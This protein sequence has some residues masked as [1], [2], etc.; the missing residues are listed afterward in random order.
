[1]AK[2]RDTRLPASAPVHAPVPDAEPVSTGRMPIRLDTFLPVAAAIFLGSLAI[3][4]LHLWQIRDA[5]FF[6]FLMGDAQSYHA[7]AQD[8]AAGN[9]VGTD[10][11]YQAPLYPYFLGLVYTLFGEGAMVVRV[12]QAVL[13]SLACVFLTYA[14]W[15]LFSKPVGLIAGA[16]LALYAPALFFDGLIQKSV[17]DTVFLCLTLALLSELV[18][19]PARRRG[20]LAVGVA[21][22]CLM[23]TRENAL[24]F[25]IVML[26]WLLWPLQRLTRE[27]LAPAAFLLA[28]LALVLLPVAAR[29]LAVNGE[30][31][32]TTSQFGPNFYIGNNENA[33]GF[34]QPLRFGR[35]DPRFER[36]DATDLAQEATGRTLSP[37]EVSRYWTGRALTY[38][39]SQPVDW[40]Q[41]MGRKF[42]LAWNASE[43][44]DTEDQ[45]SYAD[46]SFPLSAT[47][48]VWHFGILAP[49]AL[50]GVWVTWSRRRDLTLLYLLAGAYTVTLVAFAIMARYRYPLVPFLILFAAAGVAN[51]GLLLRTRSRRQLAWG[52]AAV[53]ALAIFCNWP[54]YSMARMRAVTDS[55]VGTELQLRGDIDAAI[56]L[57]RESLARN[58]NNAVAISNLGTALAANGQ[59]D[60]AITQHRRALELAPDDAD[61]HFNLGNALAARGD[62]DEAIGHLRS[63]LEV[64]PGFAEAHVN[65]GNVLLDVE[66]FEEAERH[67]RRAT[68]LE[69][70]WVQPF[71]NLGLLIM[72]QDRLAEGTAIFRQALAVDPDDADAHSNLGSALQLAG[73]T[74][75]ALTHFRRVIE[76]APD[77]AEAHN[78]LGMAL[79][80]Q[81][82]LEEA[83]THFERAAELDP[84]FVEAHNNLAM[85]AQLRGR[86]DEAIAR[87]RD[88]LRIARNPVTYN[89]LGIILAQQD[90]QDEAITRFRQAIAMAPDQA[91]AHGNLA[92]LLQGRGELDDAITHFQEAVR[93]A[94]DNTDLADRLLAA[95]AA[96]AE[97]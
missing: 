78:D 63:A 72:A 91:D 87:Y 32:L 59:L 76:L 61:G 39:W 90:R 9:W 1:M 43:V 47:G 11:F 81:Q 97:R 89:D 2:R 21:V 85:T 84:T 69:P 31:H 70:D 27:R 56:A 36:E 16:M 6:S 22:G 34:Y 25:A 44:A 88:I 38:I 93:L 17:L 19:D 29:N 13:G 24:V 8:L 28:G 4:L 80:S 55:N 86:T 23:L 40:L 73:Q 83:A 57:Y 65:L 35:G 50:V 68:E 60:E 66:E 42:M 12:C 53:A 30:F 71:N 92:M 64:D 67:Y 58:P 96:K 52:G 46:E 94:P 62:L 82:Q 33:S 77:S 41:L 48:A 49:L 10:V 75:E 14:G 51:A 37:G 20:W 45:L 18:S 5:P 79:G 26:C 3:R 7:W 15:R 74:A 95:L 54:M